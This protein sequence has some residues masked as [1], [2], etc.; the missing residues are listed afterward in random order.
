M[1]DPYRGRTDF[2]HGSAERCAVV[3][4]NLGTPDAPTPA[5]VRRYLAEFLSDPRVIEAPR[6]IWLPVL[7]GAILPLRSRRSAH[8][9]AQVWTEAGSPLRV[10]S[11]ALAAGLASALADAGLPVEVRLAMRY[12]QPGL[13]A[14]LRQLHDEGLRRLIVLPLY[15]QYSAT[16]TASVIDAVGDELRRW[17]WQPELRTVTDYYREPAWLDAVAESV[18]RHWRT[19]PRGE[20][21]L[22]SFHGIPR[23]YFLAGDPYFCQC[24]YS[25]R[26][27]AT[28]LGLADD[29]WQVTFQSRVG[30]EEWLRPYTDETVKSLAARGVKR[31][32]VI[33]P[34]FATDCLETLEEIAMQNSE[35]FLA[36]GGETLNYIPALNADAAHVAALLALLRRHGAGWPEFDP[37][38]DPAAETARLAASAQRRERFDG[39]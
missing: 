36:A 33:S 15:P 35:F 39:R 21:L 38:R 10:H 34:G 4:V 24:Q 18:R 26:E 30:R 37:A 8:A 6:L 2:R 11:Q 7:Y 32:D 16:T 29:E 14:V 22:F 9:Y 3:L 27:I 20:R 13:P 28:R 23:R 1:P 31:I 12:G 5:A 25:A 19:Q 17:R